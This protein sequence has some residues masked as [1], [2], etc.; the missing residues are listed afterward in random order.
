MCRRRSRPSTTSATVAR[1]SRLGCRPP[2]S[3]PGNSVVGIPIRRS[4]ADRARSHQSSPVSDLIDEAADFIEV[5]RR[6]WDSWEDDAEIRDVATGRFIDR[7]KLHYIDFEGPLFSVKG[8]FHHP[9]AAPG[10]APGERAGP[11]AAAFTL[12]ARIGRPGVRHPEDHATSLEHSSAPCAAT[13]RRSV[14]VASTTSDLRRPASCSSTTMPAQPWLARIGWI[15]LD[16]H[17]FRSDA[18]DLR[19]FPD[20]AGRTHD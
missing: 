5:I 7:E 12:A 6:F 3:R 14:E 16:G 20:G 4:D 8:S 17:P 2:T 13:N 1:A 18:L 10:S 19:R 9:P 15:E 11:R